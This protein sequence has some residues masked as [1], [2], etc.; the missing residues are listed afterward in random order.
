VSQQKP[1][2]FLDAPRRDP[3]KAPASERIRHFGEIY[4][5]YSADA[6][7]EQAARCLGCGIPFCEWKCPVHNF[8]P[9]WLRL[10]E[11]GN[12]FE[13]AEL[14]HRTNSLPEM[15][16]RICPQDRLCE[17]ACTLNDGHGAV[18]IGS[19]ERYITDEALRLGWRPDLSGVVPTGRRAAVI[20][21]GPAGLGAADILVRNGVTPVVFDRYPMIGGLLTFGIPPF[22]LEK[23]VIEKRHEL[24]LDMG[25]EFRLGTDVGRDVPFQTLLDEYDSVFLGMG[26]YTAVRGEFPGEDLPGVYPALPFLIGNVTR[27]LSIGGDHPFIDLAGK[28]VVVL[29]GGDTAMDCNRTALRQGATSVTCTYRRDEANLPG[30]R[31]ELR[32]SVEEGVE[33]LYNRQPVAIVGDDRVEGVKLMETRIGASRGRR[34]RRST[35]LVPGSEHVIEADAVIIAFGFRP[36]P[37]D[38]FAD[39]GIETG[40]D[41]RVSVSRDEDRPYQTT[42]PKVFSGGD[43]VR[44]ADLVVTAVYE[45]REA[46][47]G[48]LDFMG[49]ERQS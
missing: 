6:A 21:A 36:S 43:M 29:G 30:S 8:I 3:E 32:N 4:G 37:A 25:V 22:K 46:A 13:A 2:Q 14:S 45:G 34:G 31:K 28:R 19:I 18:S 40:A 10:I 26:A 23:S 5:Q 9:D 24:M 35:E 1:L 44:G 12:L 42:N 7:A 39:F 49:V 11:E 48:M 47:R 20:G 41:G 33:F 16:G 27:Q 17:G 38:W 15:C